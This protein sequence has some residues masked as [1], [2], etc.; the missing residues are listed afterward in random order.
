MKKVLST[1]FF[2]ILL[3]LV[4]VAQSKRYFTYIEKGDSLY[5]AGQFI[6]SA[7]MYSTAFASFQGKIFENDRY[8][9][10]R[11]WAMANEPD[12][13]F[14][15]LE[16]IVYK[17]RYSAHF[18]MSADTAFNSLHNN[19]RWQNLIDTAKARSAANAARVA[20]QKSLFE[21]ELAAH[22]D[23]IRQADQFYRRQIAETEKRYGR[24]S[25]E[26][27]QLNAKIAYYDSINLIKVKHILD[28][29][30]WLGPE[31]VHGGSEAMFLVIQ[32][33]ADLNTKIKYLPTMKEAAKNGKVN[34]INV[35]MLEDRI[36]VRQ[37]KKQIYG[38]QI[39]RD[40]VTGKFYVSPLI[41]PDNVDKRRAEAGLGPIADYVSHWDL[42]WDV[43]AYKK[44]MAEREKKKIKD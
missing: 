20:K 22:L 39:G 2:A 19:I 15:H 36:L 29:R 9:A 13:A 10:A 8:N 31:I 34:Q 30:G 43:E 38:T 21:P 14:G 28:T 17:D 1:L 35:A 18:R 16:R 44:E 4:T 6:Q 5:K 24:N 3:S 26:I 12:S 37:N 32:H 40:T 7:Q 33:A 41:D 27:K 25:Q 11:S 23:S 42:V